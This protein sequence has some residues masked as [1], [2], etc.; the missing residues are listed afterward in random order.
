MREI[1]VS[2]HSFP[3]YSAQSPMPALGYLKGYLNKH[4]PEA[5]VKNYFW[6]QTLVSKCLAKEAKLI[7]EDYYSKNSL[8]RTIFA[9]LYLQASAEQSIGNLDYIEKYGAMTLSNKSLSTYRLIAQKVKA[10][11]E[12]EVRKNNCIEDNII[13]ASILFNQEFSS[14]YFLRHMKNLNPEAVTV[15]GGMTKNDVNIILKCFPFVDI[16]IYGEG[17]RAF[18]EICEQYANESSLD[19]I[20]GI[21]YRKNGEIIINDY[22]T[23][24]EEIDPIWANYDDF[25]WNDSIESS[26]IIIPVWDVRGCWWGKCKFCNLNKM[27]SQ[28]RERSA[29]SILDEIRYHLGKF[30][31]IESKGIIIHFL[32]NDSHGKSQDRFLHILKELCELKKTYR[33]LSVL[34][35][36]SPIHMNEELA[37]YLNELGA[38][39]QFGF[40]QWSKSV[41]LMNKGHQVEQGILTLKLVEKYPMI[42]ITSNNLLVGFPGETVLDV[43][44]T[45]NTLYKQ[46]YIIKNLLDTNRI[47]DFYSYNLV[48][49]PNTPLSDA[50]Q[51]H[52]ELLN[53]FQRKNPITQ[54]LAMLCGNE[55]LAVEYMNNTEG[56]LLPDITQTANL[57]RTTHRELLNSL[58]GIRIEAFVSPDKTLN[59]ITV[60]KAG[61]KIIKFKGLMVDVLKLTKGIT[62]YPAIEKALSHYPAEDLQKSLEILIDKGFIYNREKIYINTLPA[63]LQFQIDLL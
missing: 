22:A 43:Y 52:N 13:G 39:I 3:P 23:P 26:R 35:E 62:T 42:K 10:F 36:L 21:A 11:I 59:I 30:R 8:F 7:P 54:I 38:T 17:E 63:S 5:S 20:P 25:D 16:C 44:E 18:A 41:K 40:E 28:Y 31:G 15:L 12:E 37:I 51:H 33:N 58:N 24:I 57:G 47:Q 29:E 49:F 27:S 60:D 45:Y 4:M 55:D 53:E 2:I 19:S 34:M 1:K 6:S 9:C 61:K 46:K 14:L 50:L 56:L 48:M 32:A